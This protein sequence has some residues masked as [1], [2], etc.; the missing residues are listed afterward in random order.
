LRQHLWVRRVSVVGN[1]GAG[2][3]TFARRLAASLDVPHIEID[4]IN[5]LPGWQELDRSELRNR[6]DELTAGDGWVV[7]GNYRECVV[8]GPVWA[9]ADTVVWL[10]LPRSVVMRRLVGRTVRRVVTRQVLWNGNREPFR[11]LWA[12]D[13]HRSII[14]WAWTQ[15]GKYA[16]RY[17]AAMTAPAYA[18]L[19]FVRLS[20]HAEAEALLA[21]L[22][23]GE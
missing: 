18:H 4:A 12:W 13:P 9:R 17:R 21:G 6:L 20:S 11:N 2:K 7:D 5:H 19:D 10:D 23:N 16:D 22:T 14:R 8:D 3:S 15:H 1:A